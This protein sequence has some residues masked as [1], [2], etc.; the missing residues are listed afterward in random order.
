[1]YYTFQ[2]MLIIIL[3]KSS[4]VFLEI[5]VRSL[6]KCVPKNTVSFCKCFSFMNFFLLAVRILYKKLLFKSFR[7]YSQDY[8]KI[9]VQGSF[10]ELGKLLTRFVS[11][12]YIRILTTSDSIKKK[13]SPFWTNWLNFLHLYE[14]PCFKIVAKKWLKE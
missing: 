3:P 14:S 12:A 5:V 6:W 2:S 13:L 10:E 1:M 8:I 9:F 7:Y 11:K 4:S